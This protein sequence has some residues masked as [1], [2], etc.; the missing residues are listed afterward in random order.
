LILLPALCGSFAFPVESVKAA[1]PMQLATDLV[2]SEF[3]FFGSGGESD[4]FIE[5]FNPTSAP[6][7]L[8]G[9]KLNGANSSGNFGN[10]YTFSSDV[11]LQPGQHFLFAH[12]GY[13]DAVE[14]DAVYLTGIVN[15]G[16]AALIRPDTSIADQVGL[17]TGTLYQ[18]PPPLEPL[19]S[20]VDQSYERNPDNSGSCVDS[21]NN[22]SDFFLRNPSDP[23]NTSS[24][25]QTCGNPT[26]TP[27]STPT[28]ISTPTQTPTA[29]STS[30]PSSSPLVLI[31]EV[32]WSGTSANANDEWIELYN[33][34]SSPVNITGWHLY[35]DDNTL[36]RVGSPDI[37][38]SG[39]I[40]P[41]TYFLLERDQLSTSITANQVYTSSGDLLNTGERLYL[42]DSAGNTVDTANL[43]GGTWP[44][45]TASPN[46]ASMERVGTTGNQWVTYGGT[47]PVAQ[48]RNGGPIK[49]TP[50]RANW[51]S[52][53]TITTITSDTPDP[54]VVNQNVT[55]AVTVIGGL[56]TPTGTVSIT[57]ANT[58]CTITLTNGS[59]SCAVRFN[60]IGTKTITATYNGDT[61]HPVLSNDTESH[62]VVTQGTVFNTPT[63][64]P[65]PPPQLVV[66]NEFVPRAGHDWNNDGV[67]NVGD[68]YIELL[69][70]GTVD[71]NLTGFRLDDEVNIGSNPY[72]L[73]AKIL[74][75]G[76]RVVFYGSETSL[77]LSDGGDGVR[78]LKPNGQLMDAYNYTVVG[79]PDQSYCRLPDNG[80]ADDWNKNCFPT[81][82]YQNSLSE[83][84]ALPSSG[85]E[86]ELLCPIADTLPYDF[87]L[88]ECEGFG[89][90][91]WRA[92]FW[93]Q[94]G[95][96]DERYL[97][98][99]DGKWPVFAD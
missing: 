99:I 30:T 97:P 98:Q 91:I 38:L 70:H 89:N 73:P 67:V 85:V 50:G 93:D 75:P 1:P 74:K 13:D 3:R 16:G 64:V 71:V 19:S 90:N 79:Y 43:D 82:G 10:R 44:A 56:T 18:E 35:G 95:W 46:Y 63:P 6:V 49:G 25:I 5:I 88:A 55:V 59:G 34:G 39:T 53:T 48:D 52:T 69:N 83:S 84:V 61:T 47:I 78:L 22:A 20:N 51:I 57:G 80:G 2:I 31:N 36:N 12:T 54:S 60:S 76:E 9:W 96:Y 86:E 24:P 66:I 41:N 26:P 28:S 29:T 40:N 45:G 14:P 62:Q 21:N 72:S 92:E 4:E 42:K 23:Q 33:P 11:L 15:N 65:P 32:A 77:L 17:S 27:T 94:T 87:V 58:N 68:E 8:N 37:P 81:P 7:N